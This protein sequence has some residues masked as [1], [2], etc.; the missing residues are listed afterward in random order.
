M[1][2]EMPDDNIG[3]PPILEDAV[4]GEIQEGGVNY[5]DVG[6]K[7]TTVLMMKAQ[8][9]LGVLSIPQVFDTLG[10]IPGILIVLAISGMTCWSNWMVGVFKMRHPEVYGIDD[11]GRKIFGRVGFEVLGAAYA[12]FWIFVGG[13]G[14]LSIS[15]ALN[16]LSNHAICTAIYVI[17]AAA[18]GFA[19]SSIQTMAKM[20]LLAW[21]GTGCIIVAVSTVTIA[22]GVQGHPPAVD[23]VIPEA[24]YKLFGNPSF[25][26][27]MA[28][29]S[30]VCLS[31]AGTPA[32]FHIAAEMRDPRLYTR[33]LA[34]S[35]TIIT[36]IY[37]VCG[38]V[39]YYYCGSHVASPALGSA[40]AVIKKVC[41]GIALPGLIVSMV[42][43]LHLPAKQIFVRML[44][45]S[46]H[47]TAHT[48]IHWVAWLGSTF[49]VSLVAYIIASAIPVFSS[50]VSF[51]GALFGTPI[52]FQPFGC[53]WL[54]DNWGSGTAGK[55]L[56]W[57]LKAGWSFFMILAGCFLTIAGTYG[58]IV[59]IID[60]YNASGGSSAWS[61]ANNDV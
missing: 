37:V 15:I 44:R 34:V 61:C 19:F 20:S 14:M 58:S 12:L 51:V 21:I 2:K 39:V 54:Y 7:G 16:A 42:F 48:L 11:V 17:I 38:T 10:I 40:G 18:L 28:A 60:S 35:Q 1:E 33:S 57:W 9:G 43:L 26:D 25:A 53:M 24:D 29:V 41:Y 46:K 49:A 47:L 5:R 56:S 6:W 30:T 32:F 45:G 22:V 27:A 31:Y 8:M 23:G 50:L 55:P 3:K 52:C 36:V 4:F 59:S 13:S